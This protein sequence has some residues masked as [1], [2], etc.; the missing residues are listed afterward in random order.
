[1]ASSLA[2]DADLRVSFPFPA[3]PRAWT[4]GP[5]AATVRVHYV[6]GGPDATPATLTLTLPPTFDRV[7]SKNAVCTVDGRKA[8]CALPADLKQAT[9]DI[10][11]IA[12]DSRPGIFGSNVSVIGLVDDPRPE[13][14][15]A[16]VS[17]VLFRD[18]PFSSSDDS[19]VD[20]LRAAIDD[21]NALCGDEIPCR[22]RGT[23]AK[24]VTIA[25]ASSLPPITACNV[26]LESGS[27]SIDGG[28]TPRRVE[29]DGSR[30]SS[31]NGFEIRTRCHPREDSLPQGTTIRGFAIGG[32]PENGILFAS[33]D[34]DPAATHRARQNCIGVDLTAQFARPNGLRGVASISAASR[35]AIDENII[36]AN[37]RSG[38]L[39]WSTAATTIDRN[40]IGWAKLTTVALP[41]GASGIFIG[42]DGVRAAG[43]NIAFNEQFG[44]SIAGSVH[45]A[46]VLAN[47]IHSNGALAIDWRLDGATPNDDDES[48]GIP[49]T[50]SV[51]GKVVQR[52]NVVSECSVTVISGVVKSNRTLGLT[53]VVN[54]Y[55][56]AQA[57]W[58][59]ASIPIDVPAGEGP[60][61]AVYSKSF[62]YTNSEGASVTAQLVVQDRNGEWTTSEL[63][64]PGIIGR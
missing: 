35:S 64:A 25:L 15:R 46:G 8:S 19:G 62:E 44:I 7:S 30:L 33:E 23:F 11:F 16:L 49:N 50:P 43:N 38:V 26:D 9:L 57:I 28:Y 52:C 6:N 37:V 59:V 5:A 1:M 3:E 61:E 42:S 31:G 60:F 2:A 56:G 40:K 32:F 45:R 54:V 29:L 18:L 17:F 34:D 36:A 14:D 12:D 21:A 41:N 39:I 51:G 22:I 24:P 55:Y 53:F 58:P 4:P 63:S 27:T 48:D 47:V 10:T 13:N 20:T